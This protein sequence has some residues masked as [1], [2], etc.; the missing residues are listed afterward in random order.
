MCVCV[1]VCVK[2]RYCMLVSTVTQHTL[3]ITRISD[4]KSY[5]SHIGV[6]IFVRVC[7]CVCVRMCVD[8]YC[9]NIQENAQVCSFLFVCVCVRMCADHYC[10]HIQENALSSA[11]HISNSVTTISLYYHSREC[12][13]V[14]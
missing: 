1:C 2:K 5:H 7:M 14:Y 11:E 8:Q 6:F 13:L 3:Y 4:Q 12:L 9:E 10:E